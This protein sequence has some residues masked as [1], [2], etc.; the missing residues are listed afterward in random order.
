MRKLILVAGTDEGNPAWIEDPLHPFQRTLRAEGLEVARSTLT[1]LPYRWSTKLAG[2]PF[3][4]TLV[5]SASGDELIAFAEEFS[6]DDLNFFA[7]SHGGQVVIEAVS[8][9]TRRA[10]TITTIGTPRRHDMPAEKAAANVAFW[11]HVLDRDHD[12]MATLPRRMMHKLTLGAIGD[13]TLSLERRFILPNCPN[14]LNVAIPGIGH[15]DSLQKPEPMAKLVASGVFERIR[16]G[17]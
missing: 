5:W 7:L 9:M 3:M 12:K 16:N 4:S 2:L 15:S 14:V 6:Y 1:G 10:R 13:G 17:W 8:K 11:Q